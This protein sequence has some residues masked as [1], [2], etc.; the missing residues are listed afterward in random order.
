MLF[1]L[2]TCKIMFSEGTD[3][4]EKMKCV[5]SY[6]IFFEYLRHYHVLERSGY[7]HIIKK[8]GGRR[9]VTIPTLLLLCF[10]KIELLPGRLHQKKSLFWAGAVYAHCENNSLSQKFIIKSPSLKGFIHMHL[11]MR[12]EISRNIFMSLN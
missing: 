1:R 2:F 12:C 11:F 8:K 6:E 7:L 4:L 9:E 3:K 10:S 5:S